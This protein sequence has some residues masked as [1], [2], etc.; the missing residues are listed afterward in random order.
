MIP[1]LSKLHGSFRW[2]QGSIYSLRVLRMMWPFLQRFMMISFEWFKMIS[3]TRIKFNFRTIFRLFHI[4]YRIASL[5]E[6]Q[7]SL[8]QPQ[9]MGGLGGD[10]EKNMA[11]NGT[12]RV[13]DSIFGFGFLADSFNNF[14]WLIQ[15]DKNKK[16]FQDCALNETQMAWLKTSKCHPWLDFHMP[17][18]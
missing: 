5:K 8:G 14:S 13:M 6:L 12:T 17:I 3:S 9:S 4:Y 11:D 2:R 15:D 10:E 18:P 7:I 16:L 1:R